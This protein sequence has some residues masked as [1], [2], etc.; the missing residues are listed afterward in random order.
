MSLF[1][2]CSKTSSSSSSASI[3]PPSWIQGMWELKMNGTA[4]LGFEF[5]NNDIKTYQMGNQ[6]SSQK[7]FID[8]YSSAGKSPKTTETIAT[9]SYDII[10]DYGT[11]Q[12]VHYTFTKKSTTTI[13]YVQASNAVYTKK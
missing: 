3:N 9:D 7:S 13:A 4:Y 8:Q 11:G 2:S 12:S 6:I 1:Y 5:T 10:I